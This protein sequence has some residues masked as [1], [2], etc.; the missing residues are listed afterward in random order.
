MGCDTSPGGIALL[1]PFPASGVSPQAF[2][3]IHPSIRE[4]HELIQSAGMRRVIGSDADAQG[5]PV[6]PFFTG[7]E[8]IEMILKTKG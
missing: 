2:A 7:I 5:K 8:L 1:L 4:A 6:G 3:G